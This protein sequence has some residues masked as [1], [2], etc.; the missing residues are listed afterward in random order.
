MDSRLTARF[1]AETRRAGAA[2]AAR[3]RPG[4]VVLLTGQLGAGKSEFA[5][6]VAQG[7][8]VAVPVTSPTFTL[9]NVY[10]TAL[11]PLHHFDW[12]R[13]RDEEEIPAAG[14]DEYVGGEAVTLIEWHERAP[15]LVPADHVEVVLIPLEDGARL[16]DLL[17]RGALAASGRF[18]GITLN[19]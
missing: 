8:G 7:L 19:A 15:D 9:L 16:I 3:L 12:Y 17:P 10:D 18:E 4:D 11:G 6:G 1:A 13:V 5:R 2:L 14:L